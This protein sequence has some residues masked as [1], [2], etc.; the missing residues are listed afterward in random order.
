MSEKSSPEVTLVD[1]K[2]AINDARVEATQAKELVQRLTSDKGAVT[3]LANHVIR[4]ER[5]ISPLG[6]FQ[7][8]GFT[9]AVCVLTTIATVTTLAQ[10]R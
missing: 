3:L 2:N 9:V 5:A 6:R 7:Q 4:L 8:L 10:C 1:L